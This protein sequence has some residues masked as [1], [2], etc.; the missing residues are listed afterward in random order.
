MSACRCADLPQTLRAL[1]QQNP[2]K[3][4]P[5]QHTNR[6]THAFPPSSP[7]LPSAV[8]K[9]KGTVSVVPQIKAQT[10]AGSYNLNNMDP[11]IMSAHCYEAG[12]HAMAVCVD[13]VS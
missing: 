12:A 11:V 7:P 3:Q 1:L 13:K 6:S 5:Q 10:P 9:P 2:D 8:K 4:Q